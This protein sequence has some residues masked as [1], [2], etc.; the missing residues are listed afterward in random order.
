DG[1]TLAGKVKADIET[2]GKMSDLEA[3]RYDRM[4]TSG[5][6]SLA[7]FK[8]TMS[9]LPYDVTIAKSEMVFDP[10]KIELKQTTGTIGRSDFAVTGAVTNYIGY[11]FGQNET[12]KGNVDFRSNF[13]DL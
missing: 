2:R 5:S 11:V 4:P 10:R 12:V 8:L 7:D 9:D 1:M 6:A 3:E 13:L